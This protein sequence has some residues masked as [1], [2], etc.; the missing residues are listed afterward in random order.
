[1][2]W[3]ELTKVLMFDINEATGGN[4]K[5]IDKSST[6]AIQVFNNIWICIYP[7]PRKFVFDNESRFK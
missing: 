4:F 1:M 5:Y 3:F 2:G 6:R 7:C